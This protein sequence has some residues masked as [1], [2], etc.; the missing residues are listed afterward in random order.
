MRDTAS[1]LTGQFAEVLGRLPAGLNLDD[2]ALET[3]AIQRRREVVDGAALLRIALARGPGGL[4]LRQTA[5]WASMQGIADLSNPAVK[6]RLDGATE[7]L[8]LVVERLLA[9]KLPGP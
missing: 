4:S 3:K 8:A 7:F 9:A 6:Y 1:V 5:A 2:L